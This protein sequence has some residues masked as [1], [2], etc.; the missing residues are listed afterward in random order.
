MK[1]K[2]RLSVAFL[3]ACML[4]ITS[5]CTS[6][7][8]APQKPAEVPANYVPIRYYQ[9]SNSSEVSAT[10]TLKAH[11]TYFIEIAGGAGCDDSWVQRFTHN[12]Y[13]VYGGNGGYRLIKITPNVNTTITM[14]AGGAG[15]WHKP[16]FPDGQT[17]HGGG[18]SSVWMGTPGKDG[19][20]LAAAGGGGGAV[21]GTS[22]L[23][24]YDGGKGYGKSYDDTKTYHNFEGVYDGKN[25]WDFYTW[26]DINKPRWSTQFQKDLGLNQSLDRINSF[27]PQESFAAS[28]S[29]FQLYGW[30][31]HGSGGG[32]GFPTGTSTGYG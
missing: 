5:F 15:Q 30:D 31:S 28:I 25:G 23:Q 2:I 4:S 16:G 21:G 7:N 12:R 18:S 3:L 29:K 9:G 32:G 1:K 22:G 11:N 10:L 8:A 14:Y 6:A 24:G 26:N 17:K 27:N 19:T 20:L 13:D